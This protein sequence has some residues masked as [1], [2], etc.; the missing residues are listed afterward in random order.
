MEGRI[1]WRESQIIETPERPSEAMRSSKK[2]Y[3]LSSST[4]SAMPQV[5]KRKIKV[6]LSV[7]V[8]AISGW[9]GT[10][11]HPDNKYVHLT[12]GLTSGL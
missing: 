6:A 5:Q 4:P 8:D 11:A 3:T 7:D 9:L 12:H 2:L 10:G 1:V